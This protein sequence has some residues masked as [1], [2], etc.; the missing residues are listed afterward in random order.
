MGFGTGVMDRVN[1][2]FR[3]RRYLK[4]LA[5]RWFVLVL[6][7]IVSVGFAAHNAFTTPN[8]YRATS[9]IG[10]APRVVTPYDKGGQLVVDLT[11]FYENHLQYM[12]SSAVLNRVDQKLRAN[13]QFADNKATATPMASRGVGYFLMTVESVDF[14]FARQ[15]SIFWA[16]EFMSFLDERNQGVVSERLAETR[17]DIERYEKRLE[18]AR[19]TL[20]DFQ[21]KNN[22]ASVK[23]TADAAQQRLDN[24]LDEFTAIQTMRQRLENKTSQDLARGGLMQTRKTPEK[25]ANPDKTGNARNDTIDPLD[26]FLGE[27][28]FGDVD[29]QLRNRESDYNHWLK[30]LK[31]KHPYMVSLTTDLDRL[32]R[33]LQYQLEM[34]EEKRKARIESLRRD[35]ESYKPLIDNLRNQVFE[36][37]GVQNE[38]ERLKSDENDVKADLEDL[39]KTVR[40]LEANNNR[41]NMLTILEEGIGTPAPVS[42]DRQKIILSG[43]LVGLALGMGI[44]Y[45]LDRLDDRL[46]LAE[47]IETELE[48]PVLGQVPLI[49]RKSGAGSILISDMD[50]HSMF[51]E[52]IRVVRS[53]VMLGVE[54]ER[55]QVLIVTSAIPGD[56][57][58]TFTVNFAVTLAAAGNKVLLVDA[59]MRRG[60]THNYFK[61]ERTLGLADVLSGK[62]DWREAIRTTQV[63]TLFLL[64]TGSLPKNPGEL[65]IGPLTTP[66]IEEVRNEF[67][68][69][70]F[71]CPPLTA[72]DDAFALVPAADGILFVIRAG[73][74]S[75]RFAK[76]ALAAVHQRGGQIFG[77]VLNGI[78]A[79]NPYYYYN[80]YYH[81]YYRKG[82]A[83][84]DDDDHP[85]RT[86]DAASPSAKGGSAANTEVKTEGNI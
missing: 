5:R 36:S 8:K 82:R 84:S 50:E 62:T 26:R 70:V 73:Q 83:V 72:I 12:H 71:D 61:L 35:E 42:P 45:L 1:I 21:K 67:D 56:G 32:R 3:V 18:H 60:N 64:T 40:S 57:K 38:F 47:D 44:I 37:R 10:I 55:K 33:D 20:Q 19:Q 54:A 78:T 51:A 65:L 79:D 80:H 52:S 31:P 24:L 75:L 6:A 13:R 30:T 9:K 63:P 27:T 14:E 39:R 16:R 28:K 68:Y 77:I 53:A 29:L 23:E 86:D 43:L 76:N 69:I 66:F 4:M 25:S 7:V 59:D 22:I 17:R 34:I 2:Y 74:T 46:E 85:T 81:G 15:F 49:K 11:S 58:T 48:E 41:D